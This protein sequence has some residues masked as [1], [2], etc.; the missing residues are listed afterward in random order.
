MGPVPRRLP[1]TLSVRVCLRSP[2]ARGLATCSAA[3]AGAWSP[4]AS[5][6]SAAVW[7]SGGGVS[8]A[9]VTRG[10]CSMPRPAPWR[11]VPCSL[12]PVCAMTVH[13]SVTRPGTW[14]PGVYAPRAAARA[15][16]GARWSVPLGPPAA[17]GACSRPSPQPWRPATCSPAISLQRSPA[18]RKYTPA[19]GTPGCL[20]AHGRPLPQISETSGGH[21][22]S[23]PRHGVTPEETRAH[24]CQ[25]RA[26]PRLYSSL[27]TGS[28]CDRALGPAT[29][30]RA[31]TGAALTATPRPLG[32]SGKAALGPPHVSRAGSGAAL[33]A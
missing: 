13:P 14:V 21:P 25:P 29:A 28:L 27:H 23:S 18:C 22:R 2:R 24:P 11:T 17:V 19:P 4:G 26:L 5:A 16:G 1:R 10:L 9:G 33:T 3:Q 31:P 30:D 15:L 32:H 7:G 12:S 6:L 20:W 8:P